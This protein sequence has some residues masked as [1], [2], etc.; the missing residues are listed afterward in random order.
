MLFYIHP[1]LFISYLYIGLCG[2]MAQLQL[3]REHHIL[4]RQPYANMSTVLD[5]PWAKTAGKV[6][7]TER[8]GFQHTDV[9]SVARTHCTQS[10]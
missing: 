9:F 10:R 7:E 6:V 3:D 8:E 2:G 1:K 4:A 5:R